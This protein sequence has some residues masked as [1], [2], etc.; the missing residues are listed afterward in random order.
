MISKSFL[1]SAA[2]T[3]EGTYTI[4]PESSHI[5]FEARHAMITKV[6]GSF[7]DFAGT[8]VLDGNDPSLSKVELT[9]EVAS[10]GTGNHKRDDHLRTND[11]FDALRYP[12]IRFTS[13]EVRRVKENVFRLSGDLTIK[14]MTRPLTVDF[15]FTGS[16]T[17]AWG[18]H[19]AGFEGRTEV[20]RKDWGVN[21]NAALEAGG[22][23]VSEK[24]TLVFDICAVKRAER[25]G[26]HHIGRPIEDYTETEIVV[27]L[28]PGVGWFDE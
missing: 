9:I 13:T 25:S 8:A 2:R 20:N 18:N 11:F 4:E 19:C 12:Q 16:V 22:A 14:G 23:L 7:Y 6:R 3:L 27:P 10:L 17:D 28:I 1:D 26:A 15:E 24:A 5:G 21:F